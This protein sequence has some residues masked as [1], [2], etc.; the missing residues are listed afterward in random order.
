MQ[1]LDRVSTILRAN[2]NDLLDQAEDPEKMLN[3][4]A[5]DMAD[6][7]KQAKGQVTETIAQQN[8]IRSNLEK[9]RELAAQWGEKAELAV[10][11][12]K[13]DL[14]KEALRRKRDY[15]ANSK[16]YETQLAAQTQTVEKLKTDLAALESKYGELQRNK[17]ALIARHKVAQA[18]AQIQKTISTVSVTDYSSELSRMDEKIRLE[19]AR[20]AAATEIGEAS[21]EAQIESLTKSDED[22]E[23][24]AELEELKAKKAQK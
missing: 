6:A 2:I 15:E 16:V 17:E 1:I 4:I 10:S 9:S 20:A 5:R 22:L 7:I 24:D 3:Q 13:D 12:G 11:K 21:L 18:Q 8:L 23:I 14:A 19:E